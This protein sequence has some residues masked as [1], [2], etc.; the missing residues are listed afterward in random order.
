M[1]YKADISLEITSDELKMV[2]NQPS[3][4]SGLGKWIAHKKDSGSTFELTEQVKGSLLISGYDDDTALI[5]ERAVLTD[6][7]VPAWPSG[8]VHVGPAVYFTDADKSRLVNLIQS[9]DDFTVPV[10]LS[11]QQTFPARRNKAPVSEGLELKKPTIATFA[12]NLAMVN[13]DFVQKM[14]KAAA[15][16]PPVH[17]SNT[18]L[19]DHV[20]RTQALEIEVRKVVDE[21][22]LA[23][24]SIDRIILDRMFNT[25]LVHGTTRTVHSH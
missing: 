2:H 17:L 25:A 13:K 16:I 22:L 4:I 1:E 19:V 20:D 3:A 11:R 14:Q 6:T 9:K 7:T 12:G 24:H 10:S 18:G 23:V 21:G 5:L 15:E 8:R